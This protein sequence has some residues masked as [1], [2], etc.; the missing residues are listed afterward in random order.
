[1]AWRKRLPGSGA[2]GGHKAALSA[3]GRGKDLVREAEAQLRGL[4]VADLL[5]VSEIHILS[6]KSGRGGPCRGGVY[7]ARKLLRLPYSAAR[8]VYMTQS[9][10]RSFRLNPLADLALLREGMATHLGSIDDAFHEALVQ[11]LFDSYRK[12]KLMQT[13]V[14]PLCKRSGK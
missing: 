7:R 12:A 4:S 9:E 3:K 13:D 2:G 14:Y 8:S 1:M 5:Y 6:S 10:V 11:R